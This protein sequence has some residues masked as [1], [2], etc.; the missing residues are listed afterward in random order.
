MLRLNIQEHQEL[1][2]KN[3]TFNNLKQGTYGFSF[4]FL[5]RRGDSTECTI[6]NMTNYIRNMF[7][8]HVSTFL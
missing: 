1:F 2:H 6:R 8:L 7:Q 4:L 5:V 3:V